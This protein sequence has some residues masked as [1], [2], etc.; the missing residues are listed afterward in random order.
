[1][2]PVHGL[3]FEL[4]Y[5]AG[6]DPVTDCMPSPSRSLTPLCSASTA[7]SSMCS[8]PLTACS[9]SSQR[10]VP[11]RQT[12]ETTRHMPLSTSDDGRQ[13]D[14]SVET[15]RQQTIALG[16]CSG[17]SNNHAHRVDAPLR[18][19]SLSLSASSS[20]LV[21]PSLRYQRHRRPYSSCQP[22]CRWLAVSHHRY[23]CD[24]QVVS[25]LCRRQSRRRLRC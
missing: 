13:R 9:Q 11:H 1:M 24:Q 7:P 14:A 15:C 21:T 6:D 3:T 10:T 2:E 18:S 12:A 22:Q 16:V 23:R 25:R 8:A 4:V 19:E 5:G 20:C 17:A